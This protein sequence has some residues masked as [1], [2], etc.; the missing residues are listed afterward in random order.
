MTKDGVKDLLVGRDDG[1]V[2][3]WSFDMGDQPKLVFERSLQESITYVEGGMVTNPNYDEV[4]VTTYS[5]KLISFSSEPTTGL[6]ADSG[7]GAVAGGGGGKKERRERGE[8]KIRTLRDE[9]DKLRHK[10]EVERERYSRVSDQLVATDVTF[11]M[12]DK[13]A[14]NAEEARYEL[15][16]ELSMP[17][18][19]ILLQCDVPVELLEADS[20]LAIVSRTASAAPGLLATYRCQERVNRL[21]MCVRTSEGRYGNL[22]AYVWPRISPKMC[23][24]ASYPIKPLSLHTRKQS[25]VIEGELPELNSLAI[26]GAFSLAE[27]HAW[28]VLCLPEVPQRLQADE[29]SFVFRNTF[30]DTLLLADYRKGEACFKSDSL[31]TLAIVKEVVTKEATA[32]KIQIKIEVDP[33]ESTVTALLRKIDPLMT[34]Q[35]N[36]ANRVKLIET[37]K[38]VRMQEPD[39]D[40]LAP[41]YVEILENEEQIKRELKEQP[42]RLQFLHGIVVDLF[43]DNAKFKGQNVT[44]QVPNLQRVLEDYSIEALLGFFHR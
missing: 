36:L 33:K 5:G 35:L 8:R 6:E 25:T 29:A 30:L 1:I 18:D 34:Y 41:E 32:R 12:N 39:T 23:K 26:S 44:S 2:E 21:E 28:V 16:V 40:F 24:L 15:N 27:V 7:G 38:E 42:G 20:N 43:V 4:I 9:L 11:K 14:L 22:Q 17:I 19:T 10:V 37:L 31:T 13:W 3:V